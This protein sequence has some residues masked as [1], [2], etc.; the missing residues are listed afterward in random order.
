MAT[1][2][3]PILITGVGKR[4]GY[5]LCRYFIHQGIPVIGTYRTDYGTFDKL[6]GADLIHCDLYQQQDLDHLI[7]HLKRNYRG[8]RGIIHN[9]SDWVAESS[10]APPQEIFSKMMQIH[11]GVPYQINI[12]LQDLLANNS[13]TADIIHISD[14]V[15]EKGSAKHIAYAASKAALSNMTLSFASL[16]APHTKVNA[17]AP[18]LIMFNPEDNEAYRAKA[19]DK[20]VMK[21]TPGAEEVINAVDYLLESQYITGRILSLDGG[22]HIR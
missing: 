7:D 19:L 6:I 22:R 10:G 2:S 5:A 14:Y 13:K 20:S 11:A 18:S 3:N 8:L 9:A 21:I 1:S 15:V 12:A 17:I 4:I 16:L